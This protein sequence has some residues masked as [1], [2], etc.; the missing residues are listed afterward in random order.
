MIEEN[1]Q[2]LENEVKALKS[3]FEQSASMM[4]INSV[5]TTFTTSPNTYTYTNSSPY[6]PLDWQPLWDYLAEGGTPFE[7]PFYGN[8][9]ILVTFRTDSGSNSLVDLE[10][11]V[12]SPSTPLPIHIM[13]INYNGGARWILDCRPNLT[14]I[15][16]GYFRRSP[17]VL[18]ITVNS[19]M[20]GSLEVAQL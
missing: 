18:K 19:I 5:Q 9:Q 1:I 13:R 16:P 11:D 10:I 7:G 15:P 3:S 20:P 17:T 12:L 6:T 8:E 2:K 4:N 14:P